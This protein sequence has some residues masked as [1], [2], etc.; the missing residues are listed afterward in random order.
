M[1]PL[2]LGRASASNSDVLT[3]RLSGRR[4]TSRV[5]K[6]RRAVGEEMIR[7]LSRDDGVPSTLSFAKTQPVEAAAQGERVLETRED[8]R[9]NR[10]RESRCAVLVPGCRRES[11]SASQS[12]PDV[13]AGGPK[14]C[15][16]GSRARTICAKSVRTAPSRCLVELPRGDLRGNI[17]GLPRCIGLRWNERPWTTGFDMQAFRLQQ[18]TGATGLEPATF[19]FLGTASASYGQTSGG[20]IPLPVPLPC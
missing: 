20:R 6:D 10:R 12:Q 8:A 1:T 14:V 2:T 19:V 18:Q 4:L 11:P 3:A 16:S 9:P 7:P 15:E 13:R 5:S 17:L